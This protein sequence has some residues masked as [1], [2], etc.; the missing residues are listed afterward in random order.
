MWA[1]SEHELVPPGASDFL[2]LDTNDAVQ[3]FLAVTQPLPVPKERWI[4]H[5]VDDIVAYMTDRD[6]WQSYMQEYLTEQSVFLQETHPPGAA[7]LFVRALAQLALD[8]EQQLLQ[9]G[10]WDR[11]GVLPYC[12]DNLAGSDIVLRRVD[13]QLEEQPCKD[14]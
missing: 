11:H 12:F 13:L 6:E 5:Y 1:P 8:I 14:G 10:A 2:I 4:G 7:Q 3:E 9:A